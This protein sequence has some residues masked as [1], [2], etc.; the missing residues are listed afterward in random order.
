MSEFQFQAKQNDII[1]GDV[2]GD[3]R[4]DVEDVN[5]LINIILKTKTESDYSGNADVNGD[6][7]VDVEDVNAVI[8]IILK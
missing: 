5:A 4:V 2:N 1:N 8:N 7:K 3:D 6:N